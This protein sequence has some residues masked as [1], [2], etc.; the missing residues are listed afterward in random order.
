[1]APTKCFFRCPGKVVLFGI[2]AD[3]SARLQW[4]EFLFPGQKKKN[5]S[6]FVC[7][8]QFTRHCL[9]N[10]DQYEAGFAVKLHLNADTIPT[11]Q[12][13]FDEPAEQAVGYNFS[14]SCVYF[15]L[16]IKVILEGKVGC[17]TKSSSK[18]N[19]NVL[20]SPLSQS[21]YFTTDHD[22][23]TT[24]K[25]WMPNGACIYCIA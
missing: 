19:V 23:P 18:V 11:G 8:Q 2:P 4:K 25:H 22:K 1:M 17:L 21:E 5:T 14:V 7:Q 9:Y 6:V 20:M 12:G 15:V 24:Q 13:N 3:V 16:A 10:L